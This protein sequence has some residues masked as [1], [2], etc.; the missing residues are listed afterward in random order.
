MRI[1]WLLKKQPDVLLGSGRGRTFHYGAPNKHAS[2]T[3]RYK[4]GP[5]GPPSHTIRWAQQQSVVRWRS[6]IKNGS[7]DTTNSKQHEQIAQI[8]ISPTKIAPAL[9][10]KL[11]PMT[12]L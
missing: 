10:L 9:F 3:I 8:L 11:V 4:L 7:V 1:I 5:L 6:Y 12:I 2:R